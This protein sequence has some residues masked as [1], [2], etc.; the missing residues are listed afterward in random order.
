MTVFEYIKIKTENARW[1]L[2]EW[3]FPFINVLKNLPT[4]GEVR[5]EWEVDEWKG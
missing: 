3:R 2:V 1:R 5:G 4:K